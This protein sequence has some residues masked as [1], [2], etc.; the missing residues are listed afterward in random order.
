MQTIKTRI[1]SNLSFSVLVCLLIIY[2]IVRVVCVDMTHDEAYSFY[3]VKHFWYVEAL[4]T[5]NTHW[6]NF[7]AIKTAAL[8]GCEKA[9]QLRWFTM[10]SAIVFLSVGY[11]WIKS[12][13][14]LSVKTFAF[15]FLFLNPYLLDYLSLARGYAVGL[16]FE[17]LGLCFLM[18]AVAGKRP[19]HYFLAL[20][21]SG[22]AAIANFN[23]FYFFSAFGLFY[24]Y[25]YYFKH[26][27]LFLKEKR[28]YRD[29]IF[30]IG[31]A[32][33]VLRALLFI[34]KCSNDIGAYGGENLIDSVFYGFMDG[35]VYR[36]VSLPPGVIFI[37]AC[38]LFSV[39]LCAALF[40]VYH[41][42]RKHQQLYAYTS[43][44]FLLM[45]LLLLV[46]KHFFNVLYPTY[47]TTLMFF[48]LMAIML[49]CFFSE[50]LK[51][52]LLKKIILFSF[53][54]LFA[55][56]FVLSLNLYS[57]FDYPEQRD[58]K[59]AFNLLQGMGA[60]KV[61]IAPELYGVFR[62]YYQQTDKYHYAFVGESINTSVPVGVDLQINKL[63]EYEYLV[64]FPPY[65]LSFYKENKVMFEGVGYFQQTGT[66]ILRV[67]Q[68]VF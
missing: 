65:K 36:N 52:L 54:A 19:W 5:G 22:M 47:R 57:T 9:W 64:L 10:L 50:V 24:F 33:L 18:M 14:L 8:L 3:N 12:I 66:L 7:A 38:I 58:A 6:F 42:K 35:L 26:G 68:V 25:H 49:T 11:H 67:K 20:F 51:S 39:V 55:A 23:F 46:N 40:G 59:K 44:I 56:N 34:I 17:S 4:C 27:F 15:C 63:A 21:F 45:I 53:S 41:L 62:N 48:P 2:V 13:R 43:V 30:S 28:F 37:T 16:M 32:A 60:K 1:L 31:V 29:F 61:G